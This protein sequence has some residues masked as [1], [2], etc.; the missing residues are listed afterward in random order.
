MILN[1]DIPDKYT[2]ELS[3]AVCQI[4]SYDAKSG[5]TKQQFF[6][7]VTF[8]FWREMLIRYRSNT[9][10]DLAAKTAITETDDLKEKE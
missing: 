7:N 9:A 2:A 10:K 5:V 4:Y 1:F 8:S 6:K 3:D